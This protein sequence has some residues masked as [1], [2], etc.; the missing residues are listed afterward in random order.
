ME[1]YAYLTEKFGLIK[2]VGSDFHS[3]KEQ[4]MGVEVDENIYKEFIKKI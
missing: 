4:N 1:Y 2:T 3:P